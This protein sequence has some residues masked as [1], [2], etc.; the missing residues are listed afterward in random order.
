MDGNYEAP[1]ATLIILFLLQLLG[2]CGIQQRLDKISN[3]LSKIE[4]RIQIEQTIQMSIKNKL[5]SISYDIS[6]IVT[7][8]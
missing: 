4:D 6:H 2:T 5:E 7:N 3:D 8:R 1:L